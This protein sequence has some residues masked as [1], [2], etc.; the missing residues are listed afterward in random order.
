MTLEAA[1]ARVQA[2][3][4]TAEVD[5]QRYLRGEAPTANVILTAVHERRAD[6][7][8]VSTHGRSGF[9]RWYYGSVADGIV[10]GADIP[11]MLVPATVES[12]WP[13]NRTPRILVALDGSPLAETILGP[14]ARLAAQLGAELL[15]ATGRRSPPAGHPIEGSSRGAVIVGS[16][17]C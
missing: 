9:A 6:L 8:V 12:Q 10:R 13:D 5:F 3:G 4:V 14:I 17:A 1:A 2:D 16:R 11:V 15:L 7:V